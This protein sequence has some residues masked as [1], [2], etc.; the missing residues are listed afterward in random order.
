MILAMP[1]IKSRAADT[2]R[3]GPLSDQLS[4]QRGRILVAP[5]GHLLAN[6]F[7]QC[8]GGSQRP[9][10]HV[11]DQ[12]AVNVIQTPIDGQTGT[13]CCT[14]D[15]LSHVIPPALPLLI[16]YFLLFHRCTLVAS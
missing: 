14:T 1:T 6:A 11:V 9:A 13:I 7:I 3:Q 5:I 2:A 16:D 15:F 10:G 4:D 8:T 12:L